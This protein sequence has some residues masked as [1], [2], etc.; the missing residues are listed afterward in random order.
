[1]PCTYWVAR[2]PD[3]LVGCD[4]IAV[5]VMLVKKLRWLRLGRKSIV[6]DAFFGSR[7]V[8]TFP[9]NQD[10]VPEGQWLD[11]SQFFEY[12]SFCLVLICSNPFV[13]PKEMY[14][15]SSSATHA[16]SAAIPHPTLLNNRE[17]STVDPRQPTDRSDFLLVHIHHHGRQA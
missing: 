17:P 2:G 10:R 7:C 1:M 16:S 3:V 5:V 13:L 6:G 4:D 15:E 8:D 12:Y 14:A 11:T 9:N